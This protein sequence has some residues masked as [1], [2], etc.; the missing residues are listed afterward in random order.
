MNSWRRRFPA[1]SWTRIAT[2]HSAALLL[3]LAWSFSGAPAWADAIRFRIQP[4]ASEVTFRATS[5]L[6]NADGR[7]Q[8]LSGD[9]V[10]DIKDFSTA[11]VTLSIEAGSIDTGIGMRDN[12]LRSEDFLDIRKFPTIT[13][14]SQRVEGSG[15]RANVVGQ[16]TIHGVT[17]EVAVPLDVSM[18][19][20]ALVASG[21]FVINRRDYGIVYQSFLNPVGDDVRVSF[22]FRARTT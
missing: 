3:A 13:F 21:E 22:T 1:R 7:F 18:S 5:R 10:L 8:R 20:I 2:S 15:R 14:E 19:D 6:M 11:K 16:L 17:R 4:E 12:H 9:I